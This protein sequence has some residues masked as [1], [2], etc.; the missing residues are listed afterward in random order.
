MIV[1]KLAFCQVFIKPTWYGM[2]WY[3]MVEGFFSNYST[4][5]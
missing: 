4:F 1:H 2:V 3:S 5:H